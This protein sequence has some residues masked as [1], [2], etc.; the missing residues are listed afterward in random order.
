[1]SKL[2]KPKAAGFTKLVGPNLLSRLD[3]VVKGLDGNAAYPSLPVDL[4]TAKAAGASYAA[5]LADAL[6]GGKKALVARNKQ[7]ENVIQILRQL[8][9]YVELNC[10]NDLG[11]FLSSGFELA[12]RNPSQ[13]LTPPTIRKVDHG[14]AGQ[15][16]I[17]V[18]A[19]KGAYSYEA[20]YGV[21]GPNGSQ[22]ASWQSIG[23]TNTRSAVTID[24][25]TAGTIYVFQARALGP[26]G[27]SDYGHAVAY[28]AM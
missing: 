25:L 18:D 20:R 15:I 12:T 28:M 4:T 10:K 11:T 1:M 21:S 8:A 22:P 9:H 17:S 2:T 6:D 26:L 27:Y 23:F 13:P 14:N 3:A 24:N 7:R 19:L 16:L 5:S